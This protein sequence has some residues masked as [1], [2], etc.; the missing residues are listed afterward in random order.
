MVE[1]MHSHQYCGIKKICSTITRVQQTEHISERRDM[2]VVWPKWAYFK[3][4][5]AIRRLNPSKE[6][7]NI[8]PPSRP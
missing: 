3:K 2:H 4:F 6:F 1:T 8:N 7:S 5:R